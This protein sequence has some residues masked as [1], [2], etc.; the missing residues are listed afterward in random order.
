MIVTVD[1]E[2]YWSKEYS[3][4]KMS[5]TDYIL[6]PRFQVIMCAIK[7]GKR[8]VEVYTEP[9]DITRALDAIPWEDTAMLAHNTRFDGS[10]LA[11]HYHKYPALYLDT[12]G[13]ARALLHPLLGSSS[14]ATLAGFFK[15]PAKGD[16][17]IQAMGRTRRDFSPAELKTYVEYC[18]HDTDLCFKI[19]NRMIKC[20]PRSELHVIDL[21]LRMF[22]EP[23]AELDPMKLAEYLGQVRADKAACFARLSTVP[24]ETFSSA[25]K[26]ARLLQSYGVNVPDKKSPTTGKTIWALA[27]NDRAF[28]EL[29]ADPEQSPEV[30]AALACRL[31]AKST[32]E[33][34]RTA[35][36]LNLAERDWN[37][38]GVVNGNR[39]MP[40]PYRYFGAHTGR[41][42]GD[43]GYNFANLKRGSPIRDAILAPSGQRVV[44]RDASQIEA[45]ML[46]WLARCDRLVT[47]FAEGRDVY[48]EF[49]STVYDRSVS[50]KDT[51]ERF[52]GK[53]AIL[54][55]GYGAGQA[56]FRHTLFIGS[57]GVSLDIDEAESNRLV[58][59]YRDTYPEIPALWRAGGGTI[60][61]MILP[62]AT[63]M[64]DL[65]PIVEAAKDSV[66][67]PNGCALQYI[68]I[69]DHTDPDTQTRETVY[70]SPYSGSVRRIYGAKLIENITQAL[71]RIVVT[72][73]MLRIWQ[74]TGFHPALST[75]DSLDYI[76][77]EK[78]VEDFDQLLA[79]EF[80]LEPVWAPGL[81]LASEG[82]WGRTLLEAEKGVNR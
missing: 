63:W 27:R 79:H 17:S 35:T 73:I 31:N 22:I 56:K 65:I 6:D 81:P 64:A 78:I 70:D 41:F 43:G 37:G 14:L 67:L 3:L 59:L 19:F 58:T 66:H 61:R 4:T 62:P 51:R 72:D 20:F 34:T 21:A 11:W 7:R 26:F 29:C 32:I 77:P 68:N 57:G 80:G 9:D 54:S 44:H 18:A 2:T 55:L 46:A 36:L 13:M 12:L 42:A 48:S 33:E 53:T 49:A 25:D 69:R 45:R 5:E 28:K 74:A 52:A 71:A 23:Q 16:E 82:G 39:W 50:K 76:V 30:Q 1:Y 24:E 15:L 47:A 38:R 8:P 10:I 60:R 40:V 75:Y